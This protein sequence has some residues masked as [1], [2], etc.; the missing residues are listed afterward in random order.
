[1]T[2]KIL[3]AFV[4]LFGLVSNTALASKWDDWKKGKLTPSA[5]EALLPDTNG[6]LVTLNTAVDAELDVQK[7]CQLF[8]CKKSRILF[9][10]ATSTFSFL[11]NSKLDLNSVRNGEWTTDDGQF[12]IIAQEDKKVLRD[13][14]DWRKVSA[15]SETVCVEEDSW[16]GD[17]FDDPSGQCRNLR[18]EC[19]K[20][21]T[22]EHAAYSYCARWVVT[23]QKLNFQIRDSK[24]KEI[25]RFSGLVNEDTA[26]TQMD[27]QFCK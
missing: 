13:T 11:V 19:K 20:Y 15:R 22:I 7:K 8:S 12:Q 21:E 14:T 1:M 23:Q 6:S 4:I 16:C 17:V 26:E 3:F 27:S 18:S 24:Q 25:A 5:H 10:T 2:P 9:K